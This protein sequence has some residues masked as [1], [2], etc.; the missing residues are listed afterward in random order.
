[1]LYIEV[2]MW[3]TASLAKTQQFKY[4]KIK[5]SKRFLVFRNEDRSSRF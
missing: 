3:M 4:G 2:E 1:M 5:E